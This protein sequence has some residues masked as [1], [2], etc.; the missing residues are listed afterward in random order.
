VLHLRL[1]LPQ[2]RRIDAVTLDGR[3]FRRFDAATGTIDLSGRTGS[4]LLR[5]SL[6][7]A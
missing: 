3:P 6:R 4:L 2:G 1:R 7:K 5:V